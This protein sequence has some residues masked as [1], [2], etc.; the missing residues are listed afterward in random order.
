MILYADRRTESIER[1]LGETERRRAKQI[2][3]KN[4]IAVPEWGIK[5]WRNADRRK[6]AE[7]FEKIERA[8]DRLLRLLNDL[9]D[10]SKLEAIQAPFPRLTYDEALEILDQQL[11]RDDL[12]CAIIPTACYW[13]TTMYCDALNAG[14]HFHGEKPLAITTRGVKQILPFKQPMK[15]GRGREEKPHLARA[16]G[17]TD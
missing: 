4:G 15:V 8:G 12:H 3:R 9:L 10:L 1:T 7:F 11:A 13:H 16:W 6:L 17:D 2:A 5:G 14:K